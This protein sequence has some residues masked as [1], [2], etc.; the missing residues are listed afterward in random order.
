MAIDL[1]E[2]CVRGGLAVLG[3]DK[4]GQPAWQ[5][6]ILDSDGGDVATMQD[7]ERGQPGRIDPSRAGRR[8][9]DKKAAVES[10]HP[11]KFCQRQFGARLRIVRRVQADIDPD[12]FLRRR[13]RQDSNVASRRP[14]GDG[15][16]P[17][18]SYPLPIDQ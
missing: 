16:P 18:V 3:R 2:D 14:T 15:V 10:P 17:L 13:A 1:T 8:G 6:G 5:V 4:Q 11:Q 7:L 12:R 9:D